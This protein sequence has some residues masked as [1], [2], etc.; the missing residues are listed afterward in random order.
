MKR[1]SI[2]EGA[3]W[4]SLGSFASKLIGAAY[5]IVLPRIL[6]DYG[7]G[8]FQMAYPLYLVLLAISVNGIPT[9]LSKQTAELYTSKDPFSAEQ[10][11]GWALVCLGVAGSGLALAMG[12]SAPWLAIHVFSEPKARQTIRALAPALALV[13]L[14]AG[15][16][17]GFQGRRQMFPTALSQVIEQFARVAVMFSLA[18]WLLPRGVGPAAAGATLGAPAG[19]LG[20]LIYLTVHRARE[21]PHPRLRWP[22]PWA[23][24][25]RL[26]TVAAPMSL[27]GLLFPL[28][29]LVD[30]IFVPERLRA[31]GLSLVQATREFGL[32]SGEAMPLI[33]LTMVVG[34]ALAI[35]LVPAVAEHVRTGHHGEAARR[36][37][38]AIHLVWL[39]GLPMSAGLYLLARPLTLLVYGTSGAAS[40]LAI[41]AVGST[42]LSMQQVL[43][44]SLQACGHGW[45]PVKNL[46]AGTVAKFALTWWLTPILGIQGA[47]LATVAAGTLTTY[48]N[49]RDWTRAIGV[50]TNPWRFVGWPLLG[51]VVM[52]MAVLTWR[53]RTR[54][55]ML[56][57]HTGVG[58]FLGAAV[59]WMVLGMSGERE[60][61]RRL[62]RS[63]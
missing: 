10:L 31:T 26:A 27:A 55:M 42:I 2:W 54:E 52:A 12:V 50:P 9:A 36:V 8:L 59:Y 20:G 16:R 63:R 1:N 11:V 14:E 47:A 6:G 34:A 40:T 24:L 25:G 57:V 48:L 43:G 19:A 53:E 56:L 45:A 17:G 58:V 44:G 41:L 32:L 28:M 22:P 23:G 61:L 13:A 30:S 62:W 39:L 15:L 7:V 60:V 37:E 3:F 51:S 35:S 21:R 18:F 46:A 4:L 5:R 33:N 38:S 49:W 29:L